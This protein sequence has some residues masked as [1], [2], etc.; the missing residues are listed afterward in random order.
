ML[1]LPDYNPGSLSW[2]ETRTVYIHGELRLEKREEEL[3]AMGMSL[4]ETARIL[5]EERNALRSWTRELMSD[6]R[7]AARLNS[8]N[9]NLSWDQLVAKYQARGFTG[10][11]LYREIMD[12]AKRS[13][14]SVNKKLSI[15]PRNPPPLPPVLPSSPVDSGPP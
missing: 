6:R 14:A 11:R 5:S 1:G 13:R 2:V 4:E 10:D 7:E 3:L 12:A 8:E 9:P 15:D